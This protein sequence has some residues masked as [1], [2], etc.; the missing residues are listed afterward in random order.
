MS[1]SHTLARSLQRDAQ[2][3]VAMHLKI[4]PKYVFYP[5]CTTACSN[6]SERHKSCYRSSE[7]SDRG[8]PFPI[9]R[10][11]WGIIF[12]CCKKGFWELLGPVL[13][14]DQGET[15][16]SQTSKIHDPLHSQPGPYP[17]ITA[18]HVHRD[19]QKSFLCTRGTSPDAEQEPPSNHF[20]CKSSRQP[21]R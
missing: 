18:V 9:L 17:T 13:S 16:A 4:Q 8:R 7:S 10:K 11:P 5:C 3:S 20:H 21:P 2:R 19:T 14:R 6:R 12:S 15:Y 1:T